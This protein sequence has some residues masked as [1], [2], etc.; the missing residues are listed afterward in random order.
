[1]ITD[2][3]TLPESKG[4]DQEDETLDLTKPIEEEEEGHWPLLSA[5]LF[6]W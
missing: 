6:W 4:A 2:T 3:D 1:M 5:F